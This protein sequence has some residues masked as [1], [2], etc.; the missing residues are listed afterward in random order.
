MAASKSINTAS[1]LLQGYRCEFLDPI[2]DDYRC[3]K[4]LLVARR[5]SIVSCCGE[6]YCKACVDSM[7]ERNRPCCKCGEREFTT[8]E[9][10]KFQGKIMALMVYCVERQKG[11]DWIGLLEDLEGH[12]DPHKGDCQCIDVECPLKCGQK[13]TKQ[14]ID[15]HVSNKCVKRQYVCPYCAFKA[16]FEVVSNRHWAD[17]LYYPL[18]CR[19]QC[20]VSCER[21]I[22]KEHLKICRLEETQ[23][24]FSQVGCEAKFLRENEEQHMRE[25][26]SKHLSMMAAG[27]AKMSEAFQGALKEQEENFVKVLRQQEM[28]FEEL[29][30]EQVMMFEEKLQEQK[31]DMK[32]KLREQEEKLE[33]L[34]QNVSRQ[35]ELETMLQQENQRESRENKAEIEKLKK[36]YHNEARAV[37]QSIMSVLFSYYQFTMKNFSS[38]KAKDLCDNWKSP[39]MYTHLCGYK[40]CIGID[41]NGCFNTRGNSVNVDLWLMRG[42]FDEHLK[43]PVKLK[44][45]IELINH[46]EGGEGRKATTVTTW[47]RPTEEYTLCGRFLTSK[48]DYRFIRHSEL[49]RNATLRTHFLKNDSLHF[50]ILHVTVL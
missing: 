29:L 2:P 3:K 38:E 44:V 7:Q 40:F 9:H 32:D 22:M 14:T 39:A 41:A 43:W 5:L 13:L 25:N 42:E 35:G 45:S 27:M 21:Y 31:N 11:C 20:G 17:C 34:E 48:I 19:N 8:F 47:D 10:V 15:Y 37:E 6:S 4:C 33:E 30:Q 18:P 1:S 28:R 46:Y 26:T 16:S 36:I 49:A 12:L 24:Q 50:R 23:C